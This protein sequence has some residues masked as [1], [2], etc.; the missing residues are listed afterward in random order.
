MTE[1][2][3]FKKLVKSSQVK[4]FEDFSYEKFREITENKQTLQFHEQNG[5]KKL[6]KSLLFKVVEKSYEKFRE[7]AENKQTLRFHEKNVIRISL[8]RC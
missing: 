7:N 6:V 1:M 4:K 8:N 2:G 5:L 3:F